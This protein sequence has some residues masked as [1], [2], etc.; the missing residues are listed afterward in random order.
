MV[1]V[2]RERGRRCSR[3]PDPHLRREVGAHALAIS[4]EPP[5][6]LTKTDR[7]LDCDGQPVA[8]SQG[9][10]AASPRRR[11]TWLSQP[12]AW[13]RE[14]GI[15]G[16]GI[17]PPRLAA[18]SLRRRAHPIEHPRSH[19]PC[20]RG[21]RGGRPPPPAPNRPPPCHSQLVT[22]WVPSGQALAKLLVQV[23]SS[24]GYPRKRGCR[25]GLMGCQQ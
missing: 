18:A 17:R 15:A 13:P 9:G 3:V 4:C 21:E 1:T 16:G 8:G 24:V 20:G 12:F 2:A 7:R 10:G 6:E 22:G 11:C 25:S 14:G 19:R 23:L 5:V